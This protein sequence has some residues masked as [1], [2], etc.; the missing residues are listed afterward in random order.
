MTM[1][2]IET[3]RDELEAMMN[4]IGC[5]DEI[6]KEWKELFDKEM[7]IRIK[8]AYAIARN[9]KETIFVE[10]GEER[11][12]TLYIKKNGEWD[13]K[14]YINATSVMKEFA[15]LAREYGVKMCLVDPLFLNVEYLK[16][17]DTEYE[18]E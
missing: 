15:K 11:G 12:Y 8:F 4:E 9:G 18:Y 14:A 1:N 7:D 13:W 5:T 3:R 17:L 2:E 10:K 6:R 16:S